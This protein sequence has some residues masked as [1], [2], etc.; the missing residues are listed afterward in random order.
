MK[1]KSISQLKKQADKNF[2]LYIR[3]KYAD[4]KDQVRCYTCDKTF[5]L[6]EI[7]NGHFVSRTYTNLR[8]SEKNCRPQCVSCNVF[9]RGAMDEFATRLERE[10]PGILAELNL[11]KHRPSSTNT[12]QD[13]LMIIE[14]YE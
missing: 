10:T 7:Q 4:W 12:R 1:T 2:S 5:P 8:W 3:K 11:W 9:K 13:L 14:K 6:K